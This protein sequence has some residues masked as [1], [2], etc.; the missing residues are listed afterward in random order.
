MSVGG[1]AG[2]Q[3]A[4]DHVRRRFPLLA[5]V[6]PACVPDGERRIYTFARTVPTSP[7]GP[8]IRQVVRVTVSGDRVVKVVLSR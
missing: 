6:A 4:I 5:G 1:D 3:A 7:G 8:A 2:R